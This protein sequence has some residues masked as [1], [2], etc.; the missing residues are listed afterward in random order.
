MSL[1]SACRVA[2][3]RYLL[4]LTLT[5]GVLS[6]VNAQ[7]TNATL[8]GVVSDPTGAVVSDARVTAI[9]SGTG[10][11]RAVVS[12]AD[13]AYSFP[14][15]PVGNYQLTVEKPGFSKY[16]QSGITLGVG[17]T[18]DVP[19]TL[20]VGDI[21]QQ[22]TVS[23]DAELVNT[24]SGTVG[25]LIDQKNIVDL[26]LNGRN[27]QALLFLSAG[28]L[29][30]TGKYCLVNCQG[31]V[32]PGEQDGNV[33]GAGTRAVNFQMDGGGHNDSYLNTNLPFP[34]P[35]AVQEF[36]VDTDNLSAQYGIGAG[37][38]VNIVTK[39]GTNQIHGD[40]FEFVRN[41]DLNARNFF[42][43]TTDTLK[44]NQYG[45]AIG[46]PI[47]KDKLFYFG[48]YQGTRIRSTSQS[49]IAFVPTAAE[50]TGN[51][52]GSGLTVADP[53]TGQPFADNQIPSS[54]LNPVAQ[55]FLKNLPQPNGPGNQLT[56]S[57]ANVVQNDDQYMIKPTWI[58]GKNQLTGSWF[59]TR[60][61]EPPDVSSGTRN[62]IASDSSGNRVTIKNLALNDTYTF[63]PTLL[64]N[65]WVAW[66]SQTGG[67]LSGAPFSFP[68]A[69]VQI[70][71]PTPPELVVTVSNFFSVS[72]N[73]LGQ[74]D[75]GDKTF[76]EDVT[77]ERGN[78]EIHVGGEA[79]RVFN[80]LVNTY[81]MSGQ[82]TFGARLSGNNLSDFLLG[83]ASTFIQGGGEY[84]NLVGTLWSLYVQDN[85]RVTPNLKVDFGVRWD[86]YFPYTEQKGRIVCY[87][88][89]ISH[90]S[91]RFPNAPLGMLFGGD[92][93]CPAGGSTDD[94]MNIAPRLGFAYRLSRNTVL[95]GGAGIYY[96]PIGNHDSNGMVDTA[97]FSPQINYTGIVNFTDPY[98]SIGIPNPFPASY[99]TS[100]PTSNAVFTIPVSI[101]GSLQ[102][103]WHL[104]E[105]AT[106][107]L[108]LE[109]S[110]G[111]WVARISYAGNKGTY[112]ASGVAGFTEQNPAVYLAGQSTESNTQARRLNPNFGS[113]GLFSSSNDS[114]YNSLRLNLEKRFSHGFSILTNYTWS[115]MID[116]FAGGGN[117]QTNP[118][119]RRFDYGLS[120][121]D[122]PWVF[123]F[124]G[125]WQI[126][127]APVHGLGGKLINGW[128][129]SAITSWRA[130]FPYS[131]YSGLDNSF[132]SVGHD[133]ADYTGGAAGLD[134]SR[135][136]GQ[137]VSQF[138]NT[139][140][141][142][143]N[144]IGTFGNSGKNI[145]F[146]PR[147]FNTDLGLQKNFAIVERVSTQ[148]RAEFFNA[149]NDVNFGVPGSTV[150][151][152]SF[153]KL[154]SAAD[155][156]ILQFALKLM[157]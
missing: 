41:G 58:Q 120:N 32:Y 47:L 107:N 61:S 121:D 75:R 96:T 105:L 101:Y 139:S 150:G 23:A 128:Q 78:Q 152:S 100:A 106:W 154:T 141:F 156:R 86:P 157:F 97:P 117:S 89:G 56:Y 52:A 64:F 83:D 31:G 34:N 63:S 65:T 55:Y 33:N 111:Q 85:I 122:V 95:R 35:D 70:A 103:N 66:T 79:V 147:S 16:V 88:P 136:H 29:N 3:S 51:F 138:F 62:I 132:S 53:A 108:N 2:V 44:R 40:L 151:G 112:L 102:H 110:F 6:P 149:F 8:N 115:K 49:S 28:T 125:L 26:P 60:F 116:D 39:S 24:Q 7:Y 140:V 92:P 146:G 14:A 135:S 113:V 126:P 72:T 133:L 1:L 98:S 15:L 9:N 38:V 118:F 144:A 130:G 143:V 18:A 74:F 30:E 69:G 80:N 45:G 11:Q 68:S 123:N 21:T 91:T 93:D 17:Q 67:S 59:W 27:P 119:F 142:Q 71:A 4:P 10:L 76:R 129:L 20:H 87:A 148:F 22:V 42:A 73:H 46:G 114:H 153:G 13:G 37:A 81:R 12:G 48:T 36:S 145:L 82:F 25:Q 94:V 84:K 57:G 104:P 19:V 50:R 99:A 5:L 43:A 109:H 134:T 54:Q 90:G 131:V 124:S 127:N 155:P 137:L 77:L